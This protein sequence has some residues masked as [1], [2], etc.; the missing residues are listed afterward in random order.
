M[1]HPTFFPTTFLGLF[2]AAPPSVTHLLELSGFTC[3]VEVIQSLPDNVI[4]YSKLRVI[5]LELKFCD[6]SRTKVRDGVSIFSKNINVSLV[7]KPHMLSLT[8]K[9]IYFVCV[10]HV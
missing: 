4:A 2:P 3:S 1:T 10:M 7:S 5:S 8:L 9:F 6:I